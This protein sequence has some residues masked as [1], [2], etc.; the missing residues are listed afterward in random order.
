MIDGVIQK[1]DELMSS[2]DAVIEKKRAEAILNADQGA[3]EEAIQ[4]IGT[5]QQTYAEAVNNSTAAQERLN[6][7]QE[8]Y[9]EVLARYKEASNPFTVLPDLIPAIAAL[10]SA[11]TAVSKCNDATTKARETWTQMQA[12][13]SNH[14]ALAEAAIS[15]EGLSE[16]MF[17]VANGF[18]T[19]GNASAD[20]LANQAAQFVTKYAEMQ[21]AAQNGMTGITQTELDE[22]RSG[23][24]LAIDEANKAGA[25][26]GTAL[27]TALSDKSSDVQAA[28]ALVMDSTAP[29]TSTDTLWMTE[30]SNIVEALR[31]NLLN[32]VIPVQQAG[33]AV[34]QSGVTGAASKKVDMETTGGELGTGVASGISGS[35]PE[36]EAAGVEIITAAE[37]GV[38]SIDLYPDGYDKG[39]N[40]GQ[41][42]VDGLNSQLGAVQAAA[43]EL[44]G[45]AAD[46]SAGRLQEQSPSKVA[47]QQG[48]YFGEGLVIGMDKMQRAVGR[49]AANLAGMAAG[50]TMSAPVS[51]SAPA[52]ITNYPR[53]TAEAAA[54]NI[55]VTAQAAPSDGAVGRALNLILNRLNNLDVGIR[56]AG[57]VMDSVTSGVNRRLGRVAALEGSGVI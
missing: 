57:Q 45:A 5:A 33:E 42:M 50:M 6:A 52:A 10:N 14:E 46:A 30:G 17:N 56:N 24:Q 21:A 4:G 31:G 8:R 38:N 40:F 26:V 51:F 12:T 15:G 54:R 23:A 20:M 49:S 41:G 34:A 36:N 9:D 37:S 11:Q 44:A 28:A 27:S 19:A 32:G 55:T 39:S 16:A 1:N 47:K 2:I 3:Y 7:A 35:A 18:L 53:Q 22:L 48:R 43:A 13:I 25:D 29:Q